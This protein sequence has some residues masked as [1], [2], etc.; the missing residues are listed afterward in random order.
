MYH[1]VYR[2]NPNRAAEMNK[3]YNP[4]GCIKF[5]MGTVVFL[6]ITY[7]FAIVYARLVNHAGKVCSGDY[8]N[9]DELRVEKVGLL[10]FDPKANYEKLYL[11][12]PGLFMLFVIALNIIGTLTYSI[13]NAH[14]GQLSPTS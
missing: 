10:D 2:T 8:K 7:F 14:R 13:C 3:P 6:R 12:I 1:R 9:N 5:I 11:T 4:P